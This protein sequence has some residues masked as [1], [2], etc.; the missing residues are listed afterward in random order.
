MATE[1]HEILRHLNRGSYVLDLGSGTGSFD[2]SECPFITVR[3]DLHHPNGLPGQNLLQADA[4]HLP[5]KSGTIDVTVANHS[6]EHLRDLE[7][8]LYETRRVLKPSGAFFVSVPDST[9]ITDRLYRWLSRGGGHVN[10]FSSVNDLVSKIESY[11]GLKHAAT[12]PL[13][14]SLSFLNRRNWKS[15][16]P[17]KL[18]LLGAG[19][20]RALLVI[21]FLFRFVDRL[22]KTRTSLYGW[23]IYFGKIDESLSSNTWTNVCVRCGAGHPSNWLQASGLVFKKRTPLRWYT[24]P[25]CGVRNI[26]TSDSEYLHLI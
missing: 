12:R 20:E 11:T 26:F 22:F 2:S 6:L 4:A 5:L 9:T 16:A 15:R 10:A 24:C 25:S 14:T 1:M 18:L 3:L 19:S 23:A 13:C 21:D 8:S 7:S 17:R